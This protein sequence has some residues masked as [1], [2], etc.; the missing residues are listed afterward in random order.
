MHRV[1]LFLTFFL[2]AA[3]SQAAQIYLCKTHQGAE[4]WAQNWCSTTGGYTVD[5]VTVPDG[6][7][8]KEQQRLAD[9]LRAKKQAAQV[10]DDKARD[11]AAACRAIDEELADISKR[12][13]HRQFN[14]TATIGKD[15]TRTRELKSKRSRMGC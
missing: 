1:A 2:V 13:D 15:Q 7:P 8:F 3:S 6:M 9:K 4:Y 5:A 14:E 10:Q 12:Y 11:K